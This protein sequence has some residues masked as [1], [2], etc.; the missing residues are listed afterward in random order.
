MEREKMTLNASELA[1]ELNI[2]RPT[3]YAL[4]RRDDFPVLKVGTRK[5]VPRAQLEEWI[6]RQTEARP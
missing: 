4:M 6:A 2:S 3:A 1:Q 5:L